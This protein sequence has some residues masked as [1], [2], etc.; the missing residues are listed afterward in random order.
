MLKIKEIIK[1]LIIKEEI[2]NLSKLNNTLQFQWIEIL[3]MSIV[4]KIR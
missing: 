3:I 2:I 1:I 4:D